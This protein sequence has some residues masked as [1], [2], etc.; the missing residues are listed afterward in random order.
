MIMMKEKLMA[1]FIELQSAQNCEKH[2]RR[3]EGKKSRTQIGLNTCMKEATTRGSSIARIAE[4]SLLY[5]RGIQGQTG[6][7]LIAVELIGHIAYSI[8]AERIPVSSRML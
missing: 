1:L 6:G 5:I 4:I 3:P 7:N 8:Q 2:F